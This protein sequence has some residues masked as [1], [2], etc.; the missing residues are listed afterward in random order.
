MIRIFSGDDHLGFR[1]SFCYLHGA[2]ED[3]LKTDGAADIFTASEAM[4]DKPGSYPCTI[5]DQPAV[6]VIGMH[7]GTLGGRVALVR[8]TVSLKHALTPED[9]R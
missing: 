9:W 7:Y 1:W 4:P 8:D 3:V 5:N 6:A 2:A